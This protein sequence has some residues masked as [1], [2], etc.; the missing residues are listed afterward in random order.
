V[1]DFHRADNEKDRR[2][3]YP[4]DDDIEDLSIADLRRLAEME[5]K[6]EDEVRIEEARRRKSPRKRKHSI[7]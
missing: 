3:H 5:K 6:W 1:I 4:E 7:S 2:C